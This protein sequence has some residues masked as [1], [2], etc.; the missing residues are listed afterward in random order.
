M[1][2]V[3]ALL[4]AGA[5]V[6]SA[7]PA[8]A[9][10]SAADVETDHVDAVDPGGPRYVRLE[11]QPFAPSLGLAQAEADAAFAEHLA[12]SAALG[13]VVAAAGSGYRASVGIPMF[14]AQEAFR[15]VY[16]HPRFEW[17]HL[18]SASSVGAALTVGYAWTW[19]FGATTSCGGG[20]AFARGSAEG[21]G[22]L[23]TLG[24]FQPRLDTS[25]GWLF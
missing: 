22:T 17:T 16:L 5:I 23:A 14:P 20:F 10:E 12:L 3:V 6:T 13:W 8:R 1:R 11:L 2:H 7:G 9:A 18:A 4:G 24:N 19:P 25:I 21:A 15:G